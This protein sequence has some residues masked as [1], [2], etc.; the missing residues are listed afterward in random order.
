M[1]DPS[2]TATDG[3]D[4][5]GSGGGVDD[6][7]KIHQL[8]QPPTTAV[9][10]KFVAAISASATPPN[11]S[12]VE[13][14]A[15]KMKKKTE[16]GGGDVKTIVLK[17][18]NTWSSSAAGGSK[19]ASPPSKKSTTAPTAS[20]SATVSLGR[21][22]KLIE[23]N[24]QLAREKE[25]EKDKE[26]DKETRAKMVIV[27]NEAAAPFAS[28]PAN[29]S[30]AD[31]I[32]RSFFDLTSSSSDRL[33]KWKSKLHTAGSGNRKSSITS[34]DREPTASSQRPNDKSSSAVMERGGE[35]IRRQ[36]SPP[37]TPPPA[38]PRLLHASRSTSNV[39][40]SVTTAALATGD[41]G[42]PNGA[43]NAP[44]YRERK[45][46]EPSVAD[47]I[48]LYH[49]HSAVIAHHG[50]PNGPNGAANAASVL[51]ARVMDHRTLKGCQ[52]WTSARDIHQQ[53]HYQNVI[54]PV[55]EYSLPP[56]ARITPFSGVIPQNRDSLLL[57]VGKNPKSG[58]EDWENTAGVRLQQRR[59]SL[60]TGSSR[61]SSRARSRRHT[62]RRRGRRVH[63]QPIKIARL[64]PHIVRIGVG[65]G[66]HTTQKKFASFADI[67]W[68]LYTVDAVV[69]SILRTRA[70]DV[71][72]RVVKTST[73]RKTSCWIVAG[74][75]TR[76]LPLEIWPTR[77]SHLRQLPPPT[78]KRTATTRI[79]IRFGQSLRPIVVVTRLAIVFARLSLS[80]RILIIL[81]GK[82]CALL[83]WGLLTMRFFLRPGAPTMTR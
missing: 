80:E 16:G 3:G 82:C 57:V 64:L 72:E 39:L 78:K 1:A 20:V 5:G 83:R 51:D 63:Q 70:R 42:P 59:R 34:A 65:V 71:R 54:Q 33:Q 25:K 18:K 31:K 46:S 11:D 79:F 38:Q 19:R 8:S 12:E 49:R 61:L 77:R 53:S 32:S 73:R 50:G 23:Q 30:F 58:K 60:P 14:S 56:P 17:N 24:V 67:F 44:P 68:R 55:E 37:P 21:P 13:A 81:S 28:K 66:Q 52:E 10:G 62:H 74:Q 43:G 29:Q 76:R 15:K 27:T 6:D 9:V 7:D 2:M 35:K 40:T 75:R 26:K 48:P 22:K 69:L 45:G 36:S 4:G 47:F 41:R